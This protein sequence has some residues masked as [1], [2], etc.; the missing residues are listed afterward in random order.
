[1]VGILVGIPRVYHG[2]YPR[3]DISLYTRVYQGGYL[4]YALPMYH[5]GIP[6]CIYTTVHPWVYHRPR[7]VTAR[8]ACYR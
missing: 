6:P 5:L 4:L 1:M 2:G 3:V 8:S 7:A